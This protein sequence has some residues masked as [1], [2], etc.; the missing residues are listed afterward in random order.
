MK[1]YGWNSSLYEGIAD[2]YD[3]CNPDFRGDVQFFIEESS[4]AGSPVL[5][6]ACGTGR[7]LIP[8]AQK[9]IRITGLDLSESML[10]IA[11][12]KVN[13]LEPAVQLNISLLPGDMRDFSLDQKFNLIFIAF[14]SFQAMLTVEDQ[15]KCLSCIRRHL[16]KG[17]RLIINLFD[18]KIDMIA[19]HLGSGANQPQKITEFTLSESGNRVIH[20]ANRVYDPAGQ[21]LVEDDIFDEI[22]P[23]GEM[24]SRKYGGLCIRWTY[25]FEMQHLLEGCGF[26]IEALYSDFNRNPFRHGEEQIWIVSGK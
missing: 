13:R 6:L 22:N 19:H 23:S 25:R 20:W 5:E 14:R 11:R 17:G 12:K 16:A 8:V 24:I 10:E 7:V 4:R 3:A 9:G 21:I 26:E 2:Y 1:D 18:P 15:K